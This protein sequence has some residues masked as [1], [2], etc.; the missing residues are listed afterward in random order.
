MPRKTKRKQPTKTRTTDSHRSTK[1]EKL[2]HVLSDGHWHSTKELV[3]RVGH[4]FHVAK[5]KLILFGHMIERR[6]HQTK[7]WQ[8]Q[9]RM[10]HTPGD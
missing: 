3:R 2:Y 6:P 8:H 9:Y 7:L 4:T 1:A 5:F 10:K